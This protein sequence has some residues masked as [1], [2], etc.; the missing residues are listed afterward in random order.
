MK[1]WFFLA[2]LIVYSASVYALTFSGSSVEL[3]LRINEDG[4]SEFYIPDVAPTLGTATIGW[5]S[6]TLDSEGNPLTIDRF[7]LQYRLTTDPA[8]TTVVISDE[9]A[10]SYE[11]TAE[12]GS[13][14]GI[15]WVI[16]ATGYYSQVST[17]SFTVN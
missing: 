1:K 4:D 14:D 16:D 8:Y 6:P 13:Y 11:L 9:A 17:F 7:E 5:T 15:L 3:P 2:S 10:T 12:V